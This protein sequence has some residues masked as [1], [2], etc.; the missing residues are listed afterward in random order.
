MDEVRMR[1]RIGDY[2]K[3]CG[4]LEKA[5]ARPFDEYIR[6]SV[7]QRFEICYELGWKMLKQRLELEAIEAKSPR[8]ALQEALQ[9]GFIRDGNAWSELQKYRN[10]T[11][12]TYDEK[13]ADEVYH[14]L[15]LKG[16]LLLQQLMLVAKTW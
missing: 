3:A 15:R 13:L 12:H 9:V 4:Q 5:I 16:L 10:L 6:D 7:I 8:Q 14:Y 2:I 11:S 1:E